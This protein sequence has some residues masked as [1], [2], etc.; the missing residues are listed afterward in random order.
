MKAVVL[1]VATRTMTPLKEF[2][3]DANDL[4]A[5]DWSPDG[6]QI[7]FVIRWPQTRPGNGFAMSLERE[8]TVYVAGADGCKP[9]VIYQT[10]SESHVSLFMWR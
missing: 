9:K 6:N 1:D 7:A 10:K 5:W 8:Y 2:S 4:M 3:R